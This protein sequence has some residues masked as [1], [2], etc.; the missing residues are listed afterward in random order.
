MSNDESKA[1]YDASHP[2]ITIR[3]TKELKEQ[4]QARAK[5]V[6]KSLAEFVLDC[7]HASPERH[8]NVNKASPD[9][10]EVRSNMASLLNFFKKNAPNLDITEPERQ[11]VKGI[12]GWMKSL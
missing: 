4:L 8:P 11:M 12:I 7:A 10:V 5:A 9:P 2:K 3:V 6:N 1:R